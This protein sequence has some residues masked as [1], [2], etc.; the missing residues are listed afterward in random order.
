MANNT[1]RMAFF[2]ENR[3][4]ELVTPWYKNDLL[5]SSRAH[6]K[7]LCGSLRYQRFNVTA[8]YAECAGGNIEI[9][10]VAKSLTMT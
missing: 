1:D 3:F 10:T 9:A 5:K 2:M 4:F 7:S 8:G 6:T